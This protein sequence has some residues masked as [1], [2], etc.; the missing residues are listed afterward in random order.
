MR[1]PFAIS[2][3]L[4]WRRHITVD[5]NKEV[6][7][8][9]EKLADTVRVAVPMLD[10]VIDINFYP[11]DQAAKANSRW[12]PV[13]L[14]VM[15]LQDVFFQ[16]RLAFD[17]AEAQALS[18]KIQEEIYFHALVASA[19]LAEKNG[20]HPAFAE[21]RHAKGQFQFDLWKVEPTGHDRWEALRQLHSEDGTA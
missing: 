18:A 13:G 4:T 19:E 14:G 3:P 17:S 20:A 7:F 2:A 1:P 6:V 21:T 11:V 16:L 12:R 15:G 5:A 8:D 9:F 10:R